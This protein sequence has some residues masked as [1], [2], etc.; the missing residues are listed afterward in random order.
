MRVDSTFSLRPSS[1]APDFALPNASGKIV[2]LDEARGSLGTIVF[3]ACNHCPYV[4]HLASELGPFA[5][6]R[7]IS[8]LIHK[9][10]LNS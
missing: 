8:P 7:M 9:M 10:A 6:T 2:T 5:L 3:F 4:I 1:T